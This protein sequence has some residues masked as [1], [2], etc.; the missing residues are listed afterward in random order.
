MER[1]GS[2]PDPLVSQTF[3]METV[4]P[5]LPSSASAQKPLAPKVIGYLN[6]VFG[7][8][9]IIGSFSSFGIYYGSL[10][11][12]AGIN[13]DLARSDAFYLTCMR[14]ITIPGFIFVLLQ[15]T[16]GIGLFK[17]RE[18]AR[19]LAI[20]CAI[21]GLIAGLFMGWLA[22]THVM[23]F[24]SSRALPPGVDP[25]LAGMTKALLNIS[26][27]IGMILGLFYPILII[28]FLTRPRLRV[29]FAA[30]RAPAPPP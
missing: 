15:L 5:P 20:F 3:P 21:Y 1:D 18:W 26:G 4:P 13:A 10:E 30:A 9:G 14:I 28:F 25:A 12:H 17:T 19:Q 7:L 2:T 16:S 24:A 22:L 23:P 27:V 29:H 11:K 6:I 8:I